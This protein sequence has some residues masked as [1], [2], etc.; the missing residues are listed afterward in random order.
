MPF[1]ARAAEA[2]PDPITAALAA[3]LGPATEPAAISAVRTAGFGGGLATVE[4][5][6]RAASRAERSGA[7]V[8]AGFALV[9]AD[10]A[11][12]A[13]AGAAT[14]FLAGGGAELGRLLALIAALGLALSAAQ[15]LFPGYGLH[16]HEILRRRALAAA[17]VAGV[18]AAF[19]AFLLEDAVAAIAVVLFVAAAL[20]AQWVLRRAAM[21]GLR[22]AGL[23]GEAATVI[24]DAA[25]VQAVARFLATNWRLG[26]RIATTEAERPRIALIAGT[27]PSEAALAALRLRHDE[28]VLLAALPGANGSGFGAASVGGAIGLRLRSRNSGAHARA[29]RALDVAIASAL[30]AITGPLI[31]LAAAAIR[32]ADPGPAVY[33]QTRVGCRGQTFE[34]LKLR[35]MFVDADR[36]LEAL[37]AE[38]AEARE[39]WEAHFKL[40]SDPRVIPIVGGLLRSTSIDELPQLL[41]VI[42]GEMS[43]VGPR[44][45]PHYHLD[46][47]TPGF[48]AQRGSVKPGVTGLWQI[49]ER[50]EADVRRVEDLDGFYIA[51]R[52]FWLDAYILLSTP[53]AAL[54]GT[55]AY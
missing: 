25:D 32:L 21:A 15:G 22:R 44:P 41:N 14:G 11:G 39:E 17:A 31:L 28:I 2:L 4:D 35:T 54:R 46:A 23:W 33:R 8:A 52:S 27:P 18:G 9:A 50:S 37:L 19:A 36:R 3:E 53:E 20:L 42:S 24:G 13:A 51:N 48:R 10:A 34:I 1:H 29:I 40:R 43:L 26:L 38:D 7:P 47:M 30:L 5:A 16:A 12:L 45:F 49:S 55:G 6:E